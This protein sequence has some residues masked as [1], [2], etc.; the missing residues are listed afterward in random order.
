MN[1]LIKS[2]P[3]L[4]VIALLLINV[5]THKQVELLEQDL[6]NYSNEVRNISSTISHIKNLI[7]ND[8]EDDKLLQDF[9]F[10]IDETSNDD[11]M[12]N[13]Q[14]DLN[15][16]EKNAKVYLAYKEVAASKQYGETTITF[17]GQPSNVE[18]RIELASNDN[19][20]FLGR[21]KANKKMRYE[22]K[23][24]VEN[25]ETVQST[26]LNTIDLLE[27][28]YP[29]ID[30]Q[31]TPDTFHSSGRI[32]VNY[33]LS[34]FNQKNINITS[35]TCSLKYKD[36]IYDSFDLLKTTDVEQYGDDSLTI[37]NLN[38][39]CNID[40]GIGIEPDFDEVIMEMIVKTDA[41]ITFSN[42]WPEVY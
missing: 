37:Y 39:T 34:I 13:V 32:D 9:T 29:E 38:R 31:L 4:L 15:Q 28:Y 42:V 21:F 19:A 30:I 35:A 23:L 20:S 6:R 8:L 17:D 10:T 25:K 24:I 12:I 18:K 22:L 16:F 5:Q 11:S 33:E 27:K 40:L 1:K 3:Y 26:S 41:G 7:Q 2:L 36:K 14:V